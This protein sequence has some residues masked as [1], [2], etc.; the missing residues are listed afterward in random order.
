MKFLVT[1]DDGYRSFGINMIA[2]LLR[3]LGEVTV[4]APEEE[5]SATSHSLTL[6]R[7]LKVNRQD[8][9]VYS[10]DGTPTDC[11]MLAVNGLVK[12]RPDYVISGI[13]HG[14]NL[15]DDV[16][17]S[18][19]VAAAIEGTLLGIPSIAVSYTSRDP[20]F[21]AEWESPLLNILK[22]ITD[23]KM[24]EDTLLNLNLPAIPVSESRGVKVTT[25]GKRIYQDAVSSNKD[26]RGQVYYR[27]GG[28]QIKWTGNNSSDF[29]AINEGYVSITPLHL[30]LTN[31][32]T[33]EELNEWGIQIHG[34]GN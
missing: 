8:P 31:Y 3:E 15:G 9:G 5:M 1:N 22:Q 33:L 17:Y 25:L 2:A 32:R 11:V 29:I 19:T 28:Q 18:G 7:P 14:A 26:E 6:S 30:D 20:R 13:N 4:V 27:I 34:E 23:R 12:E 16:T 24:P 10:I 21:L